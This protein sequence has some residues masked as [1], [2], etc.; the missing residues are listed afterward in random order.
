MRSF[1]IIP[2]AGLSRRMK[3]QKL[4]LPWGDR[5]VIQQVL[6]NWKATAVDR[7]V[8]VARKEDSQISRIGRQAGIDLVLVESTPDMKAS[9]LRGVQFLLKTDSPTESDVWLMAPADMPQMA[10]SIVDS[11]LAE[12]APQSPSILIPA[13]QGKRGHPVLFPWCLAL[14]LESIPAD[15]GVNY[16]LQH[17]P[18]RELDCDDSSILNDVDTPD[19]YER[20]RPKQRNTETS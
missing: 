2:A 7:L 13:W 4:L 6:E 12:H 16:L 20:L 10:P 19:D 15:R 8:L 18:V 17:Y 9:I 14:K 3:R 1:G 5:T 11:L